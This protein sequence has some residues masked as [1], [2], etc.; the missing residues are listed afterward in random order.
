MP[1]ESEE[2]R[3]VVIVRTFAAPREL[4]FAAWT[5]AEHIGRW[6]GPNGFTITTS[7]MDV[8]PG[9][10][11]RFV[12]HGPDGTDYPNRIEYV[13]VDPPSRLSYHHGSDDDP[14]QFF[15]TILFE[16]D[17]KGTRVTM[18]SLFPTRETR[19]Y[20]VREF[21]AIEG[22][23]QTLARLDEYLREQL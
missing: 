12:M 17:G 10:L 22:G 13:E 6:W 1:V 5:D 21:R 4:V 19:D 7:E 14:R 18:R 11:R 23:N 9:G 3:E 2:E 20:V 16:E 8:R 15:A